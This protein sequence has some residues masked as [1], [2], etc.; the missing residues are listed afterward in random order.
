MKRKTGKSLLPSLTLAFFLWFTLAGL[1]YFANPQAFF[2]KP[3]FFTLLFSAS[4]ITF[5]LLFANA[6]RGFLT[7]VIITLFFAF[8]ILGIGNLLNLALLIGVAL[9][10]EFYY[11]TLIK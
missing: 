9:A 4:L 7:S 10:L 8:R 5:S 3:L 11:T 6:R 1:I 2:A